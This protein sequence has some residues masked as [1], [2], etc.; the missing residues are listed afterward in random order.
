MVSSFGT[1][2]SHLALLDM[3]PI[4]G[5]WPEDGLVP[6]LSCLLRVVV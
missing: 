1:L 4:E 3:S 2:M 6:V 5:V